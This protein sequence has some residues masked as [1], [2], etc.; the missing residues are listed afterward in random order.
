MT[1]NEIRRN[2]QNNI[3]YLRKKHNL[4]QS[5]IAKMTGKAIT[6]V[7]T[8]EQGK[9]LPDA[10]TLYVLSKKLGVT[11][12]FMYENTEYPDINIVTFEKET[13]TID[14]LLKLGIIQKNDNG[15]IKTNSKAA[16]QRLATR[17]KPNNQD[18]G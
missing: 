9:T 18:V 7:A 1:D 13:Y 15:F 16:R 10:Y 4:T 5:D 11:M 17:T 14:E 12:D 6:T 3:S 2:I 8:W